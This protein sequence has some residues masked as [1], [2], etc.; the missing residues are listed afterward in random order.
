MIMNEPQP[1]ARPTF[2]PPDWVT[3]RD[4]AATHG[5]PTGDIGRLQQHGK[6]V[7]NE[8]RAH[9]LTTMP[10][11][12]EQADSGQWFWVYVY[13]EHIVAKVAWQVWR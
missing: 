12:F 8:L 11:V 3:I 4:Y 5:L 7:M 10:K 9:G 13:P 6:A 2:L 1:A